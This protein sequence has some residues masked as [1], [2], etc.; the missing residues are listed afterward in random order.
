MVLK[1]PEKKFF[2]DFC[3]TNNVRIDFTNPTKKH[4]EKILKNVDF[5][6]EKP[7]MVLGLFDT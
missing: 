3:L 4:F 7:K 2:Q 6:K 5:I 1:T